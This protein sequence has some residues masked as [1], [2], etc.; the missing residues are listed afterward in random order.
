[1]AYKARQDDATEKALDRLAELSQQFGL[2]SK[3]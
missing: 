3:G 2:Y 1:V